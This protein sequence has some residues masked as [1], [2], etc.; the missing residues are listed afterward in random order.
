MDPHNRG[1]EGRD[2]LLSG[3]AGDHPA[4][5]PPEAA[6]DHR[7]LMLAATGRHEEAVAGAVLAGSEAIIP[8]A[9]I[10]G[11]SNFLS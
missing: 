2:P 5:A 10:S 1:E 8:V 11:M 9:E 7:S 6:L 4:L 3:G